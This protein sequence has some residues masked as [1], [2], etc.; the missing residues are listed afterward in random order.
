MGI[1]MAHTRIWIDMRTEITMMTEAADYDKGYDKGS[2]RVGRG[3]RPFGSGYHR[4]KP[5]MKTAMTDGMICPG[6]TPKE[7]DSSASTSQSSRAASNFGGSK[8]ADTAAR[9][10]EVVEWLQLDQEKLQRQLDESKLEDSLG[11]DTHAG[12]ETQEG[13]RSRTGSESSQTGP[14]P[15]LAEPLKVMP[16]PPP[17]EN[18]W[19]K[20]RSNLPAQPQSSDTEQQSPI[21]GGGKVAPVQPSEERPPMKEENKIDSMSIQKAK[22]RTPAAVQEMEGAKTTGRSWIGKLA[23]RIKTLDLQL[24][25]RNLRKIQ[26]PGSVLH[27]SMLLF[28]Q[29]VKMKMKEKTMMS[30]PLYPVLSPRLSPSWNI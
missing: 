25:Q 16:A 30:R 7:D 3:R 10:R 24:S 20:R 11:R 15:H 1:G 13:E 17:K 2:S 23:K 28:L 9:E 8:P 5:A 6:S 22:L 4:V 18:A 29:M 19:V 21:S 14:Q 27:A 12:S 26:P